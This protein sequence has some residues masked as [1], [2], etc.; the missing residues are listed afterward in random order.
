MFIIFSPLSL[1]SGH[2]SR[3]LPELDYLSSIH[4]V[5]IIILNKK[6]KRDLISKYP[7]VSFVNIPIEFRGWKVKNINDV[8]SK[9]IVAIEKTKPDLTIIMMEVWDLMREL[10]KKLKTKTRLVS[11][12]HGIP[13]VGSPIS[14]SKNFEKDAILT[15]QSNIEKSHSEYIFKHYKEARKVFSRLSIIAHNETVAQLFKNYFPNKRI[16]KYS[17]AIR[18]NTED[19]TPR[20]INRRYDFVYM[21]RMEAG[22]GVEYLGDIL[23]CISK[24]LSRKISLVILGRTDD[25]LSKI[26]LKKLLHSA[27]TSTFFKIE[28]LG[29]ADHVLKQQILKSSGVF[30][31]PSCYDTFAVVLQEALS[32]GLPCVT[33][34]IP[35]TKI[36]YTATK[37]V[38]RVQL[39]DIKKFATAS[40]RMLIN[41]GRYSSQA[42][43]FTNSFNDV[44]DAIFQ[45]TIIYKEILNQ[46]NA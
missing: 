41:K 7:N 39:F 44:K 32:Y 21:S 2:T 26:H 46:K 22:K 36:N 9:I 11:V 13:F 4:Q 42:L 20:L 24:K 37:A 35:F 23:T 12:L 25:S 1:N 33:W 18:L 8:V 34:D 31:Y 28:Y 45:D 19:S 40:V 10:S 17:S 38:S 6:S 5:T 16:W 14:S 15:A 30:L 29:W 27:K 43:K 3:I